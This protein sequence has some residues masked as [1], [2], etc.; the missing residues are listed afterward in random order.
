MVKPREMF[1]I[2][3]ITV[4]NLTNIGPLT[5]EPTSKTKNV[6]RSIP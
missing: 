4:Q 2:L 5:V 3:N 1:L 6:D